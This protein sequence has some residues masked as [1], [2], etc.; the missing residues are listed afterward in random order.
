MGQPS[1]TLNNPPSDNS[2]I[3]PATPSAS[4][5]GNLLA[6]FSLRRNPFSTSPNPRDLYWT[7]QTA[8][9]LSDLTAGLASGKNLIVLSGEPGTGKTT[10][11]NHLLNSLREREVPVA[12]VFN[13]HLDIDN[14]FDF[15]LADFGIREDASRPRNLRRALHDWLYARHRS[16]QHPILIVDEAQG[17]SAPVLEEIRM[18]LNL[19]IEGEKLIQIV[20][21]GQPELDALLATPQL[22]QLRQRVG[23]RCR[24]SPLTVAE[25]H[26]YIQRRLAAGG[27]EPGKIFA[28]EA[29]D[30]I[31]FYSGGTLR[32]INL[33]C[34]QS[35]LRAYRERILPVPPRI[36]EEVAREFQFDDFKPFPRSFDFSP[37]A[38]A[39]ILPISTSPARMRMSAHAGPS[40]AQVHATPAPTG[41]L[42]AR[43][44]G[45]VTSI[46]PPVAAPMPSVPRYALSPPPPQ[47]AKTE[48]SEK[49]ETK[50]E[51]K[52]QVKIK[53]ALQA[54]LEEKM[55]VSKEAA[56]SPKFFANRPRVHKPAMATRVAQA[57]DPARKKIQHY[58]AATSRW[59]RQP[60][61]TN[62]PR[63]K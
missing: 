58:Y 48:V 7:P 20:L 55:E 23:L 12:F 15:I 51:E 56:P 8:Q 14:L 30:A 11:I 38:I 50:I 45:S 2:P 16:G 21:S 19:E 44:L 27:A 39:D 4:Q 37:A 6:F 61:P 41:I 25:A 40:H 57:I 49:V 52:P 28:S 18:L 3:P 43:E 35:L 17:L 47:T 36:V 34:E 31:Y 22:L 60:M 32:V 59:L 33:L 62:Q 24:T 46:A 29:L 9:A 54:K 42:R 26:D 53:E 5:N 1:E 10:L 63:R 13:S